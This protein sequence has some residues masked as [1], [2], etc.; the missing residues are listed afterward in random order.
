M[1]SR[2]NMLRVL[3]GETPGWIPIVGHVD[4]YN[5]PHRDGMDPA[6]AD[7]LGVVKWCDESTI[8]FSRYIGLDI[9]DFIGA[10]VDV[11]R[12][13]VEKERRRDGDDTV[14]I[15][16]TPAGDMREVHRQCRDDGTSYVVEH[17]V[18]GADDLPALAA[19]F[20]DEQYALRADAV[21]DISRR[22]KL[23]GED[24]MSWCAMPG[25]PMGMM[26]R[27]Y[28]GVETLA[29]LYADAHDALKDLFR[30]MEKAYAEQF[31]LAAQTEVDSLV[32][33]DDTSTTT[34]SPAMFEA[35]NLELTDRRADICHAAGKIYFH[36]SCGLIKDLLP[37]YRRT[38]MDGVHGFTVPTTGN[39]TVADGRRLLGGRIAIHAGV[40]YISDSVWDMGAMKREIADFFKGV[41][42]HDGCMMGLAAY[43]HRTMG[44]TRII[45]EECRKYQ[46]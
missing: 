12:R 31:R 43:P 24:G 9:F 20:E 6:L 45:L 29:Y 34:I 5:Q 3:R 27:V 32:S 13:R 23:V 44:Q 1:T 36:H 42:P 17:L 11:S 4:P 8:H 39:V 10:P 7:K 19:V 30:V 33:M 41:G 22:R 28:S 15:W 2:E 40:P 14:E 16:H 35:C 46:R 25:T 26:Y 21:A 18:K 38:R 37:L